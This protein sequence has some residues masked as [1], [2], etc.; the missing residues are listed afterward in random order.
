MRRQI[1]KL[2]KLKHS[3]AFDELRIVFQLSREPIDQ[4]KH[5][6]DD[7]ERSMH[8]TATAYWLSLTGGGRR[9]HQYDRPPLCPLHGE[10]FVRLEARGVERCAAVEGI[11]G[12][13]HDPERRSRRCRGIETRGTP[14]F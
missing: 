12:S 1:E 7:G 8:A 14:Q 13:R 9:A 6:Y 2:R 10:L 4:A 3:H 11:A 5:R